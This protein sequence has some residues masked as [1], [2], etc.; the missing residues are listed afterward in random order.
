MSKSFLLPFF[1]KVVL[2]FTFTSFD[3]TPAPQKAKG[4]A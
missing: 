1:K 4:E 2:P 3:V